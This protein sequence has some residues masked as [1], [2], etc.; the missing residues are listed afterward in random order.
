MIIRSL[1][2]AQAPKIAG[3][4]TFCIPTRTFRTTRRY[5]TSS[6]EMASPV[7]QSQASMLATITTDLDKIAPRFEL[8][9]DQIEILQTPAEFYQTLKV[10]RSLLLSF[11]Y[12]LFCS[13]SLLERSTH[14]RQP[15]S[16]VSISVLLYYLSFCQGAHYSSMPISF[17]PCTTL[18]NFRPTLHP[19]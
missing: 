14:T 11:S 12:S 4:R 2:R 15:S 13:V 3:R 1:L 16:H 18:A 8:Q 17:C 7:P 19:Q 10:G 9:P 5:S 6:A